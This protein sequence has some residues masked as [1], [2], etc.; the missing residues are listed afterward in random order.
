MYACTIKVNDKATEVVWHWSGFSGKANGNSFTFP[1][2]SEGVY[3]IFATG[4][5]DKTALEAKSTITVGPPG[6]GPTPDPQPP[7]V[8]ITT[9]PFTDPGFRVLMVYEEDDKGKYPDSQLIAMRAFD[10]RDYMDKN[11]IKV[12]NQPEG[13]VL[14]YDTPMENDTKLW[15]DVMTLVKSKYKKTDL[16]VAIIGKGKDGYIGPLPKDA[17]DTLTLIK[18][19]GEAK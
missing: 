13:R 3:V 17:T 12:N 4:V 10:V 11:C 8:P 19:Y 14:D 5:V 15:Q 18:K 2:V 1:A 6:P 16:P 9:N 7:P